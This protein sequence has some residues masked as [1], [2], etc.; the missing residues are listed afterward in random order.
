MKY[1]IYN[2]VRPEHLQ[3]T[4]PD[5][6][7]LKDITRYVLEEVNEFYWGYDSIEDAMK[8]I[9]ENAIKLK[10]YEL[11]ILP[12]ININYNGEINE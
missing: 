6:Y 9:R 4:V 5:G 3:K 2:M 12:V 10:G 8:V 11:T 7:Y 1:K